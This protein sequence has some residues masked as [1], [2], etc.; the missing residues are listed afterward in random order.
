MKEKVRFDRRTIDRY[1]EKGLI[2]E[3]DLA[4]H[5]KSLPDDTANVE[6]VQLEAFDGD[7]PSDVDEADETSGEPAEGT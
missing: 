4:S 5:M 7:L 3:S 6:Y 1:I 2:K